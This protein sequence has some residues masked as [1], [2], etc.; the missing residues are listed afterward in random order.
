MHQEVVD[1][2]R[3]AAGG[4]QVVPPAVCGR[5]HAC[6]HLGGS[7]LYS[8][9]HKADSS[10]LNSMRCSACMLTHMTG[11]AASH[12]AVRCSVSQALAHRRMRSRAWHEYQAPKLQQML[13]P[14]AKSCRGGGRRGRQHRERVQG[15][16]EV[17]WA[18][19]AEPRGRAYQPAACASQ[20]QSRQALPQR[21]NC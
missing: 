12:P 16:S 13:P 15:P 21:P 9:S 17:G 19:K 6:P 14:S 3:Q 5:G 20:R 7:Q 11:N 10:R 4:R 8:G 1:A 18:G 2:G